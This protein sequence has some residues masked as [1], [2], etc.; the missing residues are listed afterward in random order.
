MK[1][2]TNEPILEYKKGSTE[3]KDLE[4]AL[5][6]WAG[7]VEDIPLRIGT[8]KI[9]RKLEQKQVMVSNSNYPI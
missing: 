3:R 2:P 4:K 7:K 8:E 5:E 9:T 1:K 6:K